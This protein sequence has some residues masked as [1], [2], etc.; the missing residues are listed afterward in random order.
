MMYKIG[1]VGPAKSVE[2][3]ILLAQEIEQ[4]MEFKPYIYSIAT[5]TKNIVEAHDQHV[6]FWLFSGYIPFQI[7]SQTSVPQ[8][9]LTH[10][11][12]SEAAIYQGFLEQSYSMGKLIDSVSVDII[13][14][15]AQMAA[16]GLEKIEKNVKQLFVKE[17]DV[18]IDPKELFDF[19][20]Q[21][22][23]KGKI[24]FAITCYPTVDEQLKEA[25]VPSYWVSPTKTEIYHTVQLFTEKIKTS[26]YK[27]TQIGALMLEIKD[28]DSLKERMKLG[29]QIQ[30]LELRMKENLLQLC[31]Q[32]D[33]SLIEEGNGKYTIF[34]TRG[35]IEGQIQFIKEKMYQLSI[36]MDAK[37]TA[38]IGFAQTVFNA[39]LHAHRG[40]HQTK[41]NESIDIVMI[42]DDGTIIESVGNT[43]EL[44]YSYRAED[45]VVIEKLKEASVS[46]KTYTKIQALIQKM[47]WKHFTTKDLASQLQM[48]ERN[49]QRI[50][51]DLCSVGL[52]KIYGEE[53][54]HTRG[55]PI[56]IYQLISSK[57]TN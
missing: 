35:A 50:V 48:S 37:V 42:Q 15:P 13:P 9:K 54:Q 36:E 12:F 8:D 29:Y 25:G 23:Q 32:V 4:D 24:E 51:A 27:E 17:F 31:E 43:E 49:A 14:S 46:V 38:G 26:Y 10:I 52:A 22:W 34:S 44:S 19:H 18:A 57:N 16:E 28:F 56:K 3:I 20:F 41:V 6:D 1:V 21:L 53:L 30:Y 40:L 7:A 45:P 5:E 33:G 2:R 39:E 55:R 11:F 47:R